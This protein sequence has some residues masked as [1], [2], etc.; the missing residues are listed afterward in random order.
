MS[1][2]MRPSC[3]RHLQRIRERTNDLLAEKYRKGQ[4]EH[5]GFLWRRRIMPEVMAE[6]LDL[7]CYVM[8][9]EEHIEEVKN[10]CVRGETG[11]MK[12]A[13]ALKKIKKML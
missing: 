6:T 12:P 5:G 4:A 7:V 2:L 11:D 10:L 9:L 8:T 3:E 13:E 1:D